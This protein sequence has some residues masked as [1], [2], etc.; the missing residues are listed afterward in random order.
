M[1][2]TVDR[3]RAE[4]RLPGIIE[5]LQAVGRVRDKYRSKILEK[6]PSVGQN[7]NRTNQGLFLVR[8][9]APD[10]IVANHG[11]LFLV[12]PQTAAAENW[13]NNNTSDE[14]VW[15]GAAPFVEPRYIED[16]VVGMREAG[17]NIKLSPI[18]G[19]KGEQ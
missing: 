11:S 15:F 8:S 4:G 13:L 18:L 12:R 17:L 6:R 7:S 16:V 19:Q 10:A 1:Q 2:K 9:H 5:F 14:A 3:L